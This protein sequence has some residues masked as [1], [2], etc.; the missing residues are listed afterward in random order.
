MTDKLFTHVGVATYKNRTKLR[1]TNG[2][3]EAR[4]K[5]LTKSGFTNIEFQELPSPM[6]KAQ[7]QL[8]PVVQ[9]L[10]ARHNIQPKSAVEGKETDVVEA[11]AEAA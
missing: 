8:C 2:N 4:V 6:T 10:A 5:I 7:A 11:G 1:Y 9:D 3:V